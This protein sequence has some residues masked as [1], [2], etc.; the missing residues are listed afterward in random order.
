MPFPGRPQPRPTTLVSTLAALAL[1]GCVSHEA[2]VVPPAPASGAATPAPSAGLVIGS[3]RQSDPGTEAV[4]TDPQPLD[5]P[6]SAWR[7]EEDGRLSRFEGRAR[8]PLPWW[9]RFPADAA[10]DF[11]PTTEVASATTTVVLAPVA[12]ADAQQLADEAHRA[13]YARPAPDRRHVPKESTP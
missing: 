6:V 1:A 2:R 4:F 12:E 9:Q 13:G 7:R 11:W 5:L 3:R 8:S 10:Y